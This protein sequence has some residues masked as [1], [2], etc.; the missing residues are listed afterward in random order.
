MKVAFLDRDGTINLDYPDEQWRHVREPALIEGALE[1]MRYLNQ[2]GYEIVIIT[3]QYLVGEGILSLEDYK[4]FAAALE[5]H[6]KAAGVRVLDTFFCPH[7]R[8]ENCPCCKPRDGMVRMACARYPGI[9]LS[10]SFIAGDSPADY[11]LAKGLGMRFYGIGLD[12]ENRIEG[13]ID[14]IGQ[15]V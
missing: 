12:C 3:N 15:P 11:Q 9:D 8:S 4:A 6:F 10:A 13:L 5:G 1:A 2:Q 14:L 7:S